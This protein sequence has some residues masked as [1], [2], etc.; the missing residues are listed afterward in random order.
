[1]N[2]NPNTLNPRFNRVATVVVAD[3]TERKLRRA[4]GSYSGFVSRA[5]TQVTAMG[6]LYVGVCIHLSVHFS[7]YLPIIFLSVALPISL[8]IYRVSLPFIAS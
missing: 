3:A 4:P 8:C 2:L 7:V 1:M 6:D 5:E